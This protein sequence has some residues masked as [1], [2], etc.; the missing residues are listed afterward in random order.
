[1]FSCPSTLLRPDPRLSLAP[2]AFPGLLVI[3]EVL[4][5]RPGLGCRGERPCFR[6][7]LLLRVP[8]PLRREE[9][10]GTPVCPRCPWPSST[11]HGVGSSISPSHQFRCGLC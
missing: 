5:R 6:S 10:R 11:E 1:M 4:A 7:V 9:A 8:S 2:L 3:L